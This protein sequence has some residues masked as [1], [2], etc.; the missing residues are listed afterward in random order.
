MVLSSPKLEWMMRRWLPSVKR[1]PQQT[2]PDGLDR[3]G[4]DATQ[5]TDHVAGRPSVRPSVLDDEEEVI[6]ERVAHNTSEAVDA[7][8]ATHVAAPAAAVAA[9][10]GPLLEEAVS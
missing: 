5:L 1:T 2:R 6:A 3:P 10:A 7:C 4:A 8:Q 9:P